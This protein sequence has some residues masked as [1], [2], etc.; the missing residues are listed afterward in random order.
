MNTFTEFLAKRDTDLLKEYVEYANRMI[1]E[2][3][4][5]SNKN[6]ITPQQA[7][8]ILQHWTNPI[9]VSGQIEKTSQSFEELQ[10]IAQGL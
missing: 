2:A 6:S 4:L 9:E 7:K 10:K 8:T 3:I 5:S 1:T